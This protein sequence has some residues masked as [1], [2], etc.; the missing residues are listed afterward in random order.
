M[1]CV[2]MPLEKLYEYKGINPCPADF[3]EFWELSL[4]EMRAIDPQ[5]RLTPVPYNAKI[6]DCFVLTFSSATLV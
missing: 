3:D 4:D 2:D 6:A 5:A 1:P